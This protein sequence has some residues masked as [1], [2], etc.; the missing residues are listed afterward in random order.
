M[1][2]RELGPHH[3][4]QST[5]PSNDTSTRDF[6]VMDTDPHDVATIE[7]VVG[8]DLSVSPGSGSGSAS[9]LEAFDRGRQEAGRSDASD[10][11]SLMRPTLGANRAGQPPL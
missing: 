2:D 1:I 4:R 8:A 7:T 10:G 6:I 9:A 3:D 5:L 11:L